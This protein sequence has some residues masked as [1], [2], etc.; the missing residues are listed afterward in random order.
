[1][2][3]LRFCK[4]MIFLRYLTMNI[5]LKTYSLVL[6]V[7]RQHYSQFAEDA[8]RTLMRKASK[9]V[10]FSYITE[11]W[12]HSHE[13]WEN[14]GNLHPHLH[15]FCQISGLKERQ[16]LLGLQYQLRKAD[17]HGVFRLSNFADW[18][19]PE[20]F[21]GGTL[22]HLLYLSGHDETSRPTPPV[23]IYRC[24]TPTGLG[25]HLVAAGHKT[26]TPPYQSG[27]IARLRLNE[28]EKNV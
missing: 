20:D 16:W 14:G 4:F 22:D 24:G 28:R 23:L 5:E 26:S 2:N 15:I 10:A 21:E 1:M 9:A 18:R 6:E 17:R 13:K 11:A 27:G 25:T 3:Q 8:P 12:Y 7:N 19:K